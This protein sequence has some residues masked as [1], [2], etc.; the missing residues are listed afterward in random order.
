MITHNITEGESLGGRG[1]G[2]SK[3]M[4]L[5][6]EPRPGNSLRTVVWGASNL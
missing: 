2:G 1:H 3:V 6:R 5:I 4:S